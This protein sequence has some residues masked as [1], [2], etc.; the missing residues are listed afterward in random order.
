MAKRPDSKQA[1]ETLEEIDGAFDK[2]ADW[3]TENPPIVLGVLGAILGIAAILGIVQSVERRTTNE[4]SEAVSAI[5]LAYRDAMGARPGDLA[6]P[7]PANPETAKG[8]RA[9]FAEQLLTAGDEYDG[10]QAAVNARILAGVLLDENGDL[11][12]AVEAWQRAADEAPAGP[13]QGLAHLRHGHGL[14]RQDAWA[15][16]AEAYG[17]AGANEAFPGRYLALAQSARAWVRAGEEGKALEVFA[18]LEAADPPDG[19]VP[20]HLRSQLEE[21]KTRKGISE[22]S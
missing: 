9:D 5:E 4:S 6:V 16:A 11:G 21:L 8:V 10:T 7:E 15:A 12:A 22:P 3:V 13:L 20:A 18:S 1:T 2:V 17:K 14:E 19:A